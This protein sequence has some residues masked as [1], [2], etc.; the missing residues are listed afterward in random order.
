M[1]IKP[2]IKKK[3]VLKISRTYKE[4][5]N[6]HNLQKLS[7]GSIFEIF[8]IWTHNLNEHCDIPLNVQNQLKVL[9]IDIG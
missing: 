6:I 1:F 3:N 5:Y 4:K 9:F 7:E 2:F 8:E